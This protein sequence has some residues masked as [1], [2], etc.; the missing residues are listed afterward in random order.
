MMTQGCITTWWL[1]LKQTTTMTKIKRPT[2]EENGNYA[3]VNAVD[4]KGSWLAFFRKL[5]VCID[6]IQAEQLL[7]ASSRQTHT[8]MHQEPFI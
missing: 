3:S 4:G 6:Y 8:N 1:H 5:K 2:S 7:I